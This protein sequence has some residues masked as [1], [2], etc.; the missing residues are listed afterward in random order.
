MHSFLAFQR[1]GAGL[2]VVLAMVSVVADVVPAPS[3]NGNL[4]PLF[5][6]APASPVAV[7]PNP[8]ALAFDAVQKSFE[9][10]K[11]ENKAEFSFA[12]TNVSSEEVVI[13]RV[14]T[15]CGCTAAQLPRQPW[16]MAPHESG[17]I[18]VTVDLAGKFGTINKTAT[19]LSSAGSFPLSVRIVL[20]PFDANA[21]RMGDRTRNLQVAA[22]D[23]QAVFR[24]DCASC[25]V[26]PT[27]GKVGHD[28]YDTACGI[29]HE[30]VNRASMVPALYSLKKPTDSAYW[31]Q[32]ITQ[33]K[34]HSFMPA[35]ALKSGGI[36]TDEQI[37]SLVEY[38][39]GDFKLRVR[40]GAGVP[41]S[42]STPTQ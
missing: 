24:G 23:R 5:S 18:G 16:K 39:E 22:V 27:V 2:A 6:P 12:V 35:F 38:L 33:G 10:K 1:L 3:T 19:I 11:G 31:T 32:W 13:T 20:P 21:A 34:E 4:R 17:V 29:C 26:T 41:A 7:V 25:H 14:Q 30:S 42:T 28:L 36:L 40:L 9:A 15:S 8:S 37:R